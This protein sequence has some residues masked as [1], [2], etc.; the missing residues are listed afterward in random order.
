MKIKNFRKK[1]SVYK[2]LSKINSG[3]ESFLQYLPDIAELY[4]IWIQ[5]DD[6]HATKGFGNDIIRKSQFY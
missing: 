5:I 1:V 6:L 3:I 2:Y 4:I